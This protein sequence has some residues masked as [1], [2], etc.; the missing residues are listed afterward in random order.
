VSAPKAAVPPNFDSSSWRS[1]PG[2]PTDVPANP[3]SSLSTFTASRSE[4]MIWSP[5]SMSAA[6]TMYAAPPITTTRAAQ[7]SPAARDLL[8]PIATSR[9]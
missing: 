8:N 5:V 7:V 1:S 2:R 9:R 6:T 3:N 4:E